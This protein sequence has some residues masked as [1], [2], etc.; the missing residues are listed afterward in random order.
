MCTDAPTPKCEALADELDS[1][2]GGVD[3]LLD[4]MNA[5]ADQAGEQCQQSL[6]S[7]NTQALE[8][9]R[10]ASDAGEMLA[11]LDQQKTILDMQWR[12]KRTELRDVKTQVSQKVLACASK[13][14]DL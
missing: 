6:Q 12:Q 2:V 4:D 8:L 11:N 7:Y 3:D 1:F 5:G 14:Y 10:Q 9:S 13:T